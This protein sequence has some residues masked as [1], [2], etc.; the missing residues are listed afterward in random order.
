[1]YCLRCAQHVI[2][3]TFDE[4]VHWACD[5]YE[6]EAQHQSAVRDDDAIPSQTRNHINSKNIKG[7][8]YIRT[9][10][11][12]VEIEEHVY[13][14]GPKQSY[15]A[16]TELDLV[17]WTFEKKE[18][19]KT[20]ISSKAIMKE[21]IHRTDSTQPL[22]ENKGLNLGNQ[23]SFDIWNE[24]RDMLDG[25]I[26]HLSIKACQKYTRRLVSFNGASSRNAHV[27]RCVAEMFRGGFQPPLH[28]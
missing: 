9:K 10:K 14:N 11:N 4:I 2:P 7:F 12:D 19:E 20:V 3:E 27:I 15:D 5:D 26:V 16:C 6:D 23:G 8:S 21:Q 22:V 28:Q 18:E 1:M 24:K 13:K 25:L 17:E